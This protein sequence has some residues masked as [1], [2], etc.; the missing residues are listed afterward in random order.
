MNKR[1]LL[2]KTIL[3]FSANY[4]PNIGGIEKF[5]FYLSRELEK[6]GY[7][8]VIVT[9]NIFNLSSYES[10]ETGVE[11]FRLPCHPLINGRLPIPKR[12]KR[13]NRLLYTIN[14]IQFDYVL[15]NARF[16]PHSFIGA[17]IATYHKVAPIILDHGSAYLTLGNPLF[18]FLIKIYERLVTFAQKKYHADY[19]GISQASLNWLN[20]FN[21]PGKGVISNS[22]N[23]D[24]YFNSASNR[25]YKKELNL[26]DK[27]FIVSFTGRL[28]PEKGIIPLVESAKYFSKHNSDIHF[29]L[30]G[31]GSLKKYIDEQHCSNIHLLGK[32]ETS[33]IAKLLIQSDAF[34]L[35]TRSEGF[36]TSLLEAA[37]CYTTP[38]IPNVGGVAEL[39]PSKDYG[40]VLKNTSEKSI[41]NAIQELYED[42]KKNKQLGINIGN[43]VRKYYSWNITAKKLIEAFRKANQQ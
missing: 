1:A 6:L 23:A 14:H 42:R 5:T 24:E 11:I 43:R 21:I 39:I 8:V 7:H 10:L 38:I 13:F 16:Y 34:C 3:I 37:A 36:S 27:A 33:D 17:K 40:I 19:Y 29:L 22:I 12:N 35:P 4:L 15:I 26:P 28:I 25:D 41:S 18:D 2:K 31:D 32:L 30:A 20:N 9:N